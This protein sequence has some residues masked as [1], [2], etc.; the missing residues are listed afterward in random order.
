MKLSKW[1]WNNSFVCILFN[2][3]KYKHK[4]IKDHKKYKNIMTDEVFG[5]VARKY[6]NVELDE[7][8]IGR[9][10][11][12]INP[13][14]D[15]NGKFDPSTVIIEIDGDNTNSNEYVKNWIY[16]QLNLVSSLFNFNGL[17]DDIIVDI[18]PVGPAGFDNYLIVVDY[19][20]RLALA[21]WRKKLLWRLFAYSIIAFILCMIL[22]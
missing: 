17:Y 14:L 13:N 4:L 8:W 1:L 20:S 11:G 16:K 7:D 15:I 10:Y 9:F 12:V 3:I 5:E 6:L 22:L 2:T 19:A 18:K 21:G